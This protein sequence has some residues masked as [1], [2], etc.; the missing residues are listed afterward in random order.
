MG[1]G[2]YLKTHEPIPILLFVQMFFL[3]EKFSSTASL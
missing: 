1:A 3:F 2:C